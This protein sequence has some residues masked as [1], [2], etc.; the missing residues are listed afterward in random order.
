[1]GL[2]GEPGGE[3][4]GPGVGTPGALIA[5]KSGVS[6]VGHSAKLLHFVTLLLLVL[7]TDSLITARKSTLE[8][9]VVDIVL[10]ESLHAIISYYASHIFPSKSKTV[11]VIHHRNVRNVHYLRDGKEI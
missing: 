11:L 4:R 2:T 10:F 1:M 7:W 8:S 3:E 9:R 5:S 6:V